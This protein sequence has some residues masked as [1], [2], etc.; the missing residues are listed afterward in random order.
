MVPLGMALLGIAACTGAAAP[1][2][3]ADPA[4]G[5]AG[6]GMVDHATSTGM[7]AG[8]HEAGGGFFPAGLGDDALVARY[9]LAGETP[10][11]V[12]DAGPGAHDLDVL[13]AGDNLSFGGGIGRRGL[14]WNRAGAEDGAVE[15]IGEAR[16][17]QVFAGA[18]A[19][20]VEV[21]LDLMAAHR[22]GSRVFHFGS[23]NRGGRVSLQARSSHEISF[24]VEDQTVRLW[25]WLFPRERRTVVHV[26][27]DGARPPRERVQLYANGS[28]VAPAFIQAAPASLMADADDRLWLGN[29][30]GQNRSFEGT[31]HYAAAYRTSLPSSAVRAHVVRLLANDDP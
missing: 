7:A 30:D 31:L 2:P 15:P 10:G 6:G 25:R 18:T 24:T 26:T 5:G 28:L 22:N 9:F 29:R 17:R 14:V 19:L 16:L 1:P 13:T 23:D 11:V 12:R 4:G 27:F 21:V 3:E 20:T 8:G